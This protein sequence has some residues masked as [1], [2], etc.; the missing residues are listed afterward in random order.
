MNNFLAYID[1]EKCKLCRECVEVCPTSA[2]HETNFKPRKPKPP[3]EDTKPKEASVVETIAE[4]APSKENKEA[5][6][7]N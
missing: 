3:K 6:K 4:A 7:E 1:F 2:I 5:P